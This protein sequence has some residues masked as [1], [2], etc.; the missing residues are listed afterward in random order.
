MSP[1]EP[2]SHAKRAEEVTHV[3]QV[4][5]LDPREAQTFG[6]GDD[7]SEGG[8]GDVRL[9]VLAKRAAPIAVIILLA[10][11]V[12]QVLDI[13]TAVALVLL[14]AQTALVVYGVT[15]WIHKPRT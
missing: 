7:G 13:S 9:S 6:I 14:V 11:L 3:R 10:A 8:A 5:V 12:T 1:E 4:K 15:I 2:A